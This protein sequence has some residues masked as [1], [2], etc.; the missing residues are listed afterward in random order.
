MS[1]FF[2][3]V[4]KHN[5]KLVKIINDESAK[6]FIYEDL[7]EQE[8]KGSLW[9]RIFVKITEKYQKETNS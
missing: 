6:T 8:D 2:P 5:R 4:T 9:S 3:E 1:K 7:D